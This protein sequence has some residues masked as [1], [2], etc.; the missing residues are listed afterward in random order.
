[1]ASMFQLFLTLVTTIVETILYSGVVYGW[2][3]IH[4]VFVHEQYFKADN[5]TAVGNL[6]TS[7]SDQLKNLNLV[8]TISSSLTPITLFLIGL[9][10]DRKGI[11]V[12]RT[13]LLVAQAFGYTLIAL[14]PPNYSFVLFFTI[15]CLDIGGLG[16]LTVNSQIGNLFPN[17]RSTVLTTLCGC[18]TTSAAVFLT[19]NYLY[20]NLAISVKSLFLSG[21]LLSLPLHMKT[22]FLMPKNVVPKSL[23]KDYNYGYKELPFFQKHRFRSTDSFSNETTVQDNINENSNIQSDDK[24]CFK[25]CLFTKTTFVYISHFCLLQFGCIYFLGTFNTWVK[26]RLPA[27]SS[28][29]ITFEVR[30]FNIFRCMAVII[31][32]LCGAVINKIH[33]FFCKGRTEVYIARKK[34]GAWSLILTSLVTS[35]MFAAS[36]I[37]ISYFQYVTYFLNAVT[38]SVL[39][40]SMSSNI[41]CC[42]PAKHFGKMYG[43]T[44]AVGGLSLLLQYP[45]TVA[46]VNLPREQHKYVNIFFL[47]SS[48]L[49]VLLPCWI[50]SNLR[51]NKESDLKNKTVVSFKL[52]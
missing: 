45:L 36:L 30:M 38:N 27:A 37:N 33:N 20:F 2:A 4:E 13:I 51:K 6:T 42:Y 44:Y 10:L 21:A 16:M 17:H 31:G 8:F 15:P 50:L 23:P 35:C 11:W 43:L 26:N 1:M 28:E 34:A 47:A 22:F 14:V 48:L 40:G 52:L 19:Y 32:L 12:T 24:K 7:D 9:L 46:T 18:F 3:S 25:E 49:T 29:E 5:E 41:A 39:Y